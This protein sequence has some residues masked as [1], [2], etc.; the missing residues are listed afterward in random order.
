MGDAR[1]DA[2]RWGM[3]HRPS[4]MFDDGCWR[5]WFDYWTGTDVAMGYAEGDE[6]AFLRGG[7]RVVRAGA[8]PLL[9]EWPNPAVVKVNST[10]Y[11]FADPSGYG[12]GWP[13]R[14]LAEAESDDG[15]RW[16]ILGYLPPDPDT[17]A[18]HVPAPFV[19]RRNGAD[20][21]VVF[22]ACQVGGDP[23][24]YRYDRIRYMR[25]PVEAARGNEQDREQP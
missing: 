21:L 1:T 25:R 6:E 4:L 3:Y 22:Y 19:D 5:L 15:I 24:D 12:I 9:H 8:D 13:G 7:F 2:F 20:W 11:A 17:P 18:C 10:Y 14:Q 23:Y 16:R